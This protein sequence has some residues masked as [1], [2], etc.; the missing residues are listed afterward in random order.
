VPKL[1]SAPPTRIVTIPRINMP[2][3]F[4]SA[5]WSAVSTAPVVEHAT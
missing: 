3:F 2:W 4:V 5:R 1:D